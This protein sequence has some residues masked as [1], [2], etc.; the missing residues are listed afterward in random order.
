VPWKPPAPKPPPTAPLSPRGAIVFGSLFVLA[1]LV[2]I[3]AGLGVVPIQSAPG[4]RPWV[5]VAA[6]SMFV[7][8]GLSLVNN[9]GPAGG[10]RDGGLPVA[11]SRFAARLAGY[12]LALAIVGLMCAIFAWIAFGSGERHFSTWLSFAGRPESVAS[13]ER[14]GRLAFGACAAFLAALWALFAVSGARR[15]RG[16]R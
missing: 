15:L 14:S 13:S 11:G 3:L 6:G 1:G 12:L 16:A 10:L 4:V 9:Y 8:T 7:L 5:V 2:P